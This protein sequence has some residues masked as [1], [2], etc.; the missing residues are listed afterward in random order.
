MVIAFSFLARIESQ[1]NQNFLLET[2]DRISKYHPEHTF[3]FISNRPFEDSFIFSKNTTPVLID[4]EAKSQL[5]QLYY[6]NIKI[7]KVLKKYKADIFVSKGFCSLMSKVPQILISPDLSFIHQ[8]SFVKRREKFFYKKF[9]PRFL[10][11]AKTIV[12]FSEFEKEDIVEQFKINPD[13]I[14]VIYS[15]TGENYKPLNFEEREIIKE[16][17]AGGNEF[18]IYSGIISPQQNLKNLLKGFSAF[19]KRQRSSMQLIIAG[20]AGKYFDG[21]KHSLETYKFK[22]EINLQN[23]LSE[24]ELVKLTAASYAMVDA[25]GYGIAAQSLLNAMQCGVAVLASANGAAIEICGEAALYFDAGDHKNIAE[26]MMEIFK[27]EKLRKD[28]IEKGNIRVHQ[29]NWEKSA[30]KFWKLIEG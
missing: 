25:S 11:K 23:G 8:P 4:Y 19:K 20:T 16:K 18:F 12:A 22:K 5:K 2:L 1:E 7:P 13:K 14:E 30:D 28:L 26:K 24:A 29:Y 21:F 17:Y 6:Y 10:K 3:I 15:G 9:T 27:D